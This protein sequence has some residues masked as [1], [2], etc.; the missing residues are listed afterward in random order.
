MPARPYLT[1]S[2]QIKVRLPLDLIDALSARL[3]DPTLGRAGIGQRNALIH[4]LLA[5]WVNA[6]HVHPRAEEAIAA[7]RAASTPS[8]DDLATGV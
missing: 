8:L 5:E 3:Y 2:R 7:D 4:R 6:T 1:P